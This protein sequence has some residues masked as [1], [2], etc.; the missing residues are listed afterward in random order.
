MSASLLDAH[1]FLSQIGFEHPW[2][3]RALVCENKFELSRRAGYDIGTPATVSHLLDERIDHKTPLEEFERLRETGILLYLV[4]GP[5]LTDAE[6]DNHLFGELARFGR[7]IN[8]PSSIAQTVINYPLLST[9]CK[10]NKLSLELQ[11]RMSGAIRAQMHLE[12]PTGMVKV[13]YDSFRTN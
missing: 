10:A 4:E 1:G 12:L 8:G 6:A 3:F 7:R 2:D 5:L 11:N 13:D 9:Y